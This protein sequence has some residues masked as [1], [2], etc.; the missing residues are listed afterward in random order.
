M[1]RFFNDKVVNKYRS[2]KLGLII[3]G[4]IFIIVLFIIAFAYNNKKNGKSNFN[5]E[6]K[7][8]ITILQGDPLPNLEDYFVSISDI[9]KVT[10]ST[11]DVNVNEPG[12]YNVHFK[13]NGKFQDILLIVESVVVPEPEIELKELN[14]TEG[15]NYFIEDFIVKCKDSKGKECSYTYYDESI[16]NITNVNELNETEIKKIEEIASKYSEYKN[17]GTYNID[18]LVIDSDSNVFGPYP[19]ILNINKENIVEKNETEENQTIETNQTKP[20]S[21][22][23]GSLEYDKKYYTYP[24]A[25]V[26]D[27]NNNCAAEMN[28]W[29]DDK[30]NKKAQAIFEKDHEKLNNEVEAYLENNKIF[31]KSA[32]VLVTHNNIGILNTEGKGFVGYAI[33]VSVYIW[34]YNLRNSADTDTDLKLKYYLDSNGNRTYEI[35][36]YNFK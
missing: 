8:S 16:G 34:D 32:G 27:D 5:Y 28:A 26:V 17:V 35:N 7:D 20:V 15:D 3:I 29:S 33:S 10:V 22:E 24:I 1:G 12:T 13:I 36:E 31:S 6:L 14:I 23:Y 21:C 4:V 19:T 18:I 11:N 25:Y 30:Y 2:N 9:S